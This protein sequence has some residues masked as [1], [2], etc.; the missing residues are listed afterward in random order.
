MKAWIDAQAERLDRSPSA[1]G[2]LVFKEY[3][4]Q[5]SPTV[6]E[7][8]DVSRETVLGDLTRPADSLEQAKARALA[9]ETP[10]LLAEEAAAQ[11]KRPHRHRYTTQLD[12]T[13]RYDKGTPVADFA[14]ECGEVTTSK[15]R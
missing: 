14:C 6:R 9:A 2:E 13:M 5:R 4:A 7:A 15:V 11:G 3:R 12:G 1:F 8:A 10:E